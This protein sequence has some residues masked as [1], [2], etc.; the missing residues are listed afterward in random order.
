MGIWIR[1]ILGKSGVISDYNGWFIAIICQY[2][3][4]SKSTVVLSSTNC[5]Y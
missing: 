1:L 5:I 2:V 4:R 3:H